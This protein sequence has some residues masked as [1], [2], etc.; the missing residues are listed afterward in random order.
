MLPWRFLLSATGPV[1]PRRTN[2][3][4]ESE[5][6]E[7]EEEDDDDDDD[8]DGDDDD[9]DYRRW[10]GCRNIHLRPEIPFYRVLKL[11]EM[12]AYRNEQAVICEPDFILP[13][14]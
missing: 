4:T 13:R 12:E 6:E 9:D 3:P 1:P 14:P 2:G 8:D 5:E 10:P 7:E 11:L